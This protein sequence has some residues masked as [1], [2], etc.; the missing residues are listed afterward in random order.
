MSESELVVVV[1]VG[2]AEVQWRQEDDLGRGDI[3]EYMDG[4]D[5]GPPDNFFANW[6]LW[7][8]SDVKCIVA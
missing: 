1:D 6:A 2:D 7:R 4:D 3:G 8:V 5:Q